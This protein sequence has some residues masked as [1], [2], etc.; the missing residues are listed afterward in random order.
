FPFGKLD[1][2]PSLVNTATLLAEAGYTVDIYTIVEAG[3]LP[4]QFASPRIHLLPLNVPPRQQWSRRW[5]WLPARLARALYWPLTL[6]SRHWQ[7]PY[8]CVIGVGPEG[9]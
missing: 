3:Y 9:L 6:L 8:R 2:V 1:S 4:P 7:I 5:R